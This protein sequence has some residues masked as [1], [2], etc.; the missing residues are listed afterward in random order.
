MFNRFNY[1]LPHF[2]AHR[3]TRPVKELYLTVAIMDLATAAV[4]I[5]EPIYLYTLKFSVQQILIFFFITYCLYFIVMPLGAKFANA[6]GYE[7]SIL[8]STFFLI[9]YYLSLFILPQHRWLI[10]FAPVF[11]AFQKTFYWPGYHADFARYS[12]EREQAREIS[13]LRVIDSLVYIVGPLVGGL[14]ITFSS[15]QA[16]FIVVI[17]LIAVSN[18]PLI[19]SRQPYTPHSFSYIKAYRRLLKKERRRQ[20][21]AYLGFGEELVVLVL[22]PV[23]IYLIMK[24]SLAVG[25]VVA[26]ATLITTLVT[27]YVG[28]VC[29]KHRKHPVIKLGSALYAL[30]WTL[31]VFAGTGIQIFLLDSLSR[32][33]K[34]MVYVPLTAIT[35]YRARRYDIMKGV[36]F[37][38]MS[39]VIGKLV[40]IAS[41][42]VVM[43][44]FGVSVG[45]IFAFLLAGGMSLLYNIL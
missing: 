32:I 19:I 23:F 11:L 43:Q 39:L 44:A 35:Y 17:A 45:F 28:R 6:R 13:T 15:Y 37:L 42:F 27:V 30:S 9:C 4:M 41:I 12:D 22:W 18:F 40:A 36:L 8:F 21:L 20:F 25:T 2:F 31:R 5:F 24:T 26:L 33:S 1:N 7:R 29:D 38:E 10:F 14:I 16:L 34:N 3:L